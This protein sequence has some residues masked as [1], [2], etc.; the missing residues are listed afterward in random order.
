LL[1]KV[2]A[3]NT[4]FVPIPDGTPRIIG[5]SEDLTVAVDGQS[6]GL[7]GGSTRRMSVPFRK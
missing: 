4:A 7:L 3:T 1:K 6:L 2:S 5:S